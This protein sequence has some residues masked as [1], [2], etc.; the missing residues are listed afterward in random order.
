MNELESLNPIYSVDGKEI[1]CP[2][3]YEFNLQDISEADAGRTED[4]VMDKQRIGQ[5]VKLGLAWQNVSIE[6]AARIL[7]AFQPE[8]ITVRYLDALH[9]KFVTSEFYV[10]DRSAPLY[11][12]RI[13]KWSKISFNIIERDGRKE[14]VSDD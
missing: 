10:G 4:T 11:N 12:T 7:Q 1:P 13:G 8:Y 2:S 6:N 3:T 9:G 14:G 5:C